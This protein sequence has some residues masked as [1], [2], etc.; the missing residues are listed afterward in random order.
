MIEDFLGNVM[1]TD[2]KKKQIMNNCCIGIIHLQGR[3]CDA[4]PH[5]QV[6][7]LL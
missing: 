7:N 1:T 5:C 4:D 3:K 6:V 2:L